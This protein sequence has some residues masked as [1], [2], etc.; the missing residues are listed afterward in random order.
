[1]KALGLEL[2]ADTTF[3]VVKPEASISAKTGQI[4]LDWVYGGLCL[5]YGRVFM[6]YPRGILLSNTVALAL[7]P[8]YSGSTNYTIEWVQKVIS[9]LRRVQTNDGSGAWYRRQGSDC[10][11]GL[12]PYPFDPSFPYPCTSDS[13]FSLNLIAYQAVSYSDSFQTWL[14]F[15]P[16]GGGWVPLRKVAWHWSGS[17]TMAPDGKWTLISQ[18]HNPDPPD[19]DATDDFPEWTT[20]M[21]DRHWE[22]E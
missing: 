4:A 7:P 16:S 1:L 3:S 9:I 8:G 19:S 17:G 12:Y 11:D 15:Q 21:D 5:R 13:P 2:T 6:D 10:L 18:D 20:N 14:M 22:K